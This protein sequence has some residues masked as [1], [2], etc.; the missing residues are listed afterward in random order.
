MDLSVRSTKRSE[1]SD[2]D[3]PEIEIMRFAVCYG[4]RYSFYSCRT[5]IRNFEMRLMALDT[6]VFWL[7]NISNFFA[8]FCIDY[9]Q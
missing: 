7:D 8:H 2:I 9:V 4:R 5:V 6:E 1:R 3:I